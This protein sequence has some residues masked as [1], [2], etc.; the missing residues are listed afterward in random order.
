MSLKRTAM[1]MAIAFAAAKGY[2]ALQKR[3]G[4]R[5]VRDRIAGGGAGSGGRGTLDGLLG[6]LAGGGGTGRGATGGLGGLLGALGG[7]SAG[8]PGMGGLL[9]GLAA[10]AGG[11]GAVR[12]DL[13][14]DRAMAMAEEGPQDEATARAM[15]RAI[16]QAVRA[17]GEIDPEESSALHDIMGQME[18]DEDRAALEAALREPVDPEGLAR[19]V[20][21]GHE[22]EVYAAALTAIDPDRA[23][24]RDFL[25]RFAAALRLS[26]DDVRGLHRTAGKPV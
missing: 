9:G 16:G 24:E 12:G 23:S 3:G 19:D 5:G 7:G 10:M 21:V 26:Q 1:K 4:L 11:A 22:S 18:T 20:P 14:D 17:D 2:E 8:G 15:I 6:G 13:A 25:G